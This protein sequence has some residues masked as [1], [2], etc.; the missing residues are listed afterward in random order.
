[1]NGHPV[2]TTDSDDL[3]L[4]GGCHCK[5]FHLFPLFYC[6]SGGS[7]D[8]GVSSPA[9]VLSPERRADNL[10]W[11]R[12]VGELELAHCTSQLDPSLVGH[13]ASCFFTLT[14]DPMREIG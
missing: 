2:D 12:S 1:M 7:D 11:S 6:G 3:G 4:V 8:G 14:K 5:H 9:P 13:K 10:H